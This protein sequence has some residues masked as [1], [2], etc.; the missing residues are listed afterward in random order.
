M[1]KDK[2]LLGIDLGATK[3]AA[4]VVSVTAQVL[5]NARKKT[6]GPRPAPVDPVVDAIVDAAKDAL[7]AANVSFSDIAAIG[8]GAAGL[9][10]VS[11]GTIV[12]ASNLGWQDV[13]LASLLAQR[14]DW[15]GPLIVD[16][17]TNVAAVGEH[18]AG[19]GRGSNHLFYVTV[20]T[21][22]GGG[23]IIDGNLYRGSAGAAGDFGHVIVEPDGP[24]CGCGGWGCLEVLASG[25]AIATQA[26][27]AITAGGESRLSR[28]S[29]SITAVDV[30]AAAKGGDILA[31]QVF[32][33]AARYLGIALASYAN[34]NNPEKIVIGGGVAETGD[35]LFESVRRTVRERALP[36]ARDVEIVPTQLGQRAGVVGAALLAGDSVEEL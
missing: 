32:Q 17:D 12:L 19:A 30:A 11:S 14:F 33:D 8:V 2:Y 34:T 25:T 23:I 29:G 18:R 20:G 21:G 5:G 3:I 24:K 6:P 22:I 13:P 15:T 27:Q 1:T 4:S 28:L 10:D 26:E 36:T 9:T 7:K 35:L 31:R 16:K